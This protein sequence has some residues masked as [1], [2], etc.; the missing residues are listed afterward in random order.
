MPDPRF[1]R[2]KV[3][4]MLLNQHTQFAPLSLPPET[5]RQLITTR[6]IGNEEANPLDRISTDAFA[7]IRK[8]TLARKKLNS[9]SPYDF[10]LSESGKPVAASEAR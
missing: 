4:G 9:T 1:R 2:M 3:H 7:I 6:G 10:I 8:T 5:P